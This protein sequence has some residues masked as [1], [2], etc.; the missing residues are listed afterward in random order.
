MAYRAINLVLEDHHLWSEEQ[1]TQLNTFIWFAET[2]KFAFHMFHYRPSVS[3]ITNRDEWSKLSNVILV[4]KDPGA[5]H[6]ILFNKYEGT[7]SG[8][9]VGYAPEM[10]QEMLTW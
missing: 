5:N 1:K 9:V 6:A 3:R 2:F 8:G 7:I 10:L 4:Y